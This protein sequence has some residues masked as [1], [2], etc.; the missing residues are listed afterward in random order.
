MYIYAMIFIMQTLTSVGYGNTSYGTQ[1]EWC[2]VIFLEMVSV[3][4]TALAM[5]TVVYL[6]N[7]RDRAF[8]EIIY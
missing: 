1:L 8:D 5:I 6:I 7:L 4:L 3:G 2:Y